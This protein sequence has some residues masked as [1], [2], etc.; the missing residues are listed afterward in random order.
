MWPSLHPSEGTFL[1]KWAY[2]PR[3]G[4]GVPPPLL[5]STTG[6]KTTVMTSAGLHI[7]ASSR[8]L[9]QTSGKYCQHLPTS[10][11]L[12]A[13]VPSSPV[14][15][16]HISRPTGLPGLFLEPLRRPCASLLP[17]GTPARSLHQKIHFR[18]FASAPTVRPYPRAPRGDL[19]GDDLGSVLELGAQHSLTGQ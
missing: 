2:Y 9:D 5:T 15:S 10:P 1:K 7:S 4:R 6:P 16:P 19:Q 8:H 3:S 12:F 11:G 18:P 14:S 13:S 17:S